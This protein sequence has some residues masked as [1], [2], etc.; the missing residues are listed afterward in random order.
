MPLYGELLV[1]LAICVGLVGIVLPILP[2]T[3]LVGASILVW[4]IIVG[5]SAWAV[6]AV[7]AVVMVAGEVVKYL[8][9]GRGLKAAGV[10]NTTIIVGGIV[11][12]IGFFVIPVIGLFLGFVL[13]AYVSE[14]IRNRTFSHG[15]QGA[16]AALKA[17]ATS[18][19]IELLG[20]LVASGIW[21]SAAFY[22]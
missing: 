20:A 11:G 18:M 7:A 3:L 22:Y 5:G 16:V 17:V 6:F 21:L 15:W 13:G 12:I 14:L 9:A 4:A 1:A 8:V 2:G 10:P 19:L